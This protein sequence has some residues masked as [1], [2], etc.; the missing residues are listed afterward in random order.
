[1]QIDAAYKQLFSSPEMVR[2][3][4]RAYLPDPWLCNLSFDTLEKVPSEFITHQRGLRRI[5]DA[6][7]RIKVEGQWA[8]LYLLIEFQSTVYRYMPVRIMQY[9]SLLHQDLLAANHTWPNGLLPPILPIVLYCGDAPWNAPTNMAELVPPLPSTLSAF[10]PQLRF[11]LIDQGRH[12]A[13]AAEDNLLTAMMGAAHAQ[14][15][16]ELYQALEKMHILLQNNTK[17]FKSVKDWLQTL[18]SQSQRLGSDRWWQLMERTQDMAHF[19][20]GIEKWFETQSLIWHQKG[21][22]EG[23]EEGQC[24]YFQKLLAMRFG[25]LPP[26]IVDRIHRATPRQ[27]EVWGLR[28]LQASS[29]QS[30]FVGDA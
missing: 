17:L 5:S 29:L 9:V 24:L 6:I 4:V 7:W 8:Y 14:S 18:A 13:L 20:L 1:M 27:L 10:D 2:D 12:H 19:K 16:D 15:A 28:V 25:P 22:E 30:V 11:W 23:R 3:L 21:R 26:D